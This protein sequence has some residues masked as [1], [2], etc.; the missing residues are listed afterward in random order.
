[1][2]TSSATDKE[3]QASA[4]GDAGVDSL[5]RANASTKANALVQANKEAFQQ[6]VTF[7]DFAPE[8]LTIGLVS[9]NFPD[10]REIIIKELKQ[11][12]DCQ[13]IQFVQYELNDKNLRFLQ[14]ELMQRLPSV[15]R[16]PNK[17]LVLLLTGLEASIR[18]VGDLGDYPPVLVDLNYVRDGFVTNVPYPTVFFLPDK[19]LSRLAEFAPDFWAWRRMVIRFESV[20][21]VVKSTM[22][23]IL[24]RDE[25]SE[26][27]IEKEIGHSALDARTRRDMMPRLLME[28]ESGSLAKDEDFQAFK[29]ELMTEL[30]ISFYDDDNNLEVAKNLLERS[31]ETG[32]FEDSTIV[33]PKALCYLGIIE[34]RQENYE[35][36][37][38]LLNK[39]ILDFENF[40]EDRYFN[41]RK[42]LAK[43]TANRGRAYSSTEE[44][45]K[46]LVDFSRAIELDPEYKWAITERGKTHL[47][48]NNYPEALVDFSRAIELDPEDQWATALRGYAY[49]LMER[50]SEAISDFSRAIE[51]DS[52][53]QWATAQR[54]KTYLLMD[55]YPEALADFSRA[56]ELDPEDQWATAQRGGTYLLMDSYPEALADFNRAIELDPEDQWATAQRGGTY[57]LMERYSEALADFDRAIELDPEYKRAIASRGET[58]QL[59]ERYPEAV[60]DFA[61][62]IEL[63]PEYDWAITERGYTYQL[64]ER[65]SEAVA[66]FAR[67]IELDPEYDWVIAERGYTY[68]LIERYSEAIADFNRAIRLDPEAE[69]AIASRG[70]VW[71]LTNNYTEALK[72]LNRSLEL[73]TENDWVFYHRSLVY[74]ALGQT[75]NA[76]ADIQ[77]AIQ[78]AT[79]DYEN[80]P[81]DHQTTFNLAIYHFTAGN[82]TRAKQLYQYTLT[83]SPSVYRIKDAIRDLKDLLTILPNHL[84]TE[85]ML[86]NM[87]SALASKV[88]Q[89]PDP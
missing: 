29:A 32:E 40:G 8:K 71:S 22:Q 75:E 31:L 16:E 85:E 37:F 64:M 27:N 12:P 30:G 18:M 14:D 77:Q 70:E 20:P 3:N 78:L 69:W 79:L 15:E 25:L 11:H 10:D 50:Y 57:L 9:V 67:A 2:A 38:E 13:D 34:R 47:L 45:S 73:D 19:S 58:Y 4:S 89:K 28:Y 35:K 26:L 68:R 87:Q 7:V 17:K 53:G 72:D 84:G 39:A 48:M 60:T 56:I 88:E 46:A 80:Q 23:Q 43:A 61:R 55:S 42:N 82:T 59:M 33:R 41:F 83:K 74:R 21:D 62:A 63:D 66:D 81:L 36:A 5:M 65:Y 49:R 1:M 52:E 86:S 76:E 54:G 24:R 44:Y 51:L 6:L